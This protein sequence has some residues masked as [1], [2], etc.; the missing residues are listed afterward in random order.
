MVWNENV[1]EAMSMW[2]LS[3]AEVL[4]ACWFVGATGIMTI[5]TET[6][7]RKRI[8]SAYKANLTSI[9]WRR[10]WSK[11]ANDYAVLLWSSDYGNVP[12]PP[13]SV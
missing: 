5:H 6:A 10:R 3:R 8:N 7:E 4:V 2:D 13:V 9:E 12:D 1:D 11:W